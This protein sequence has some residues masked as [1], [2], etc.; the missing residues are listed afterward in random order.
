[1]STPRRSSAIAAA[2]RNVCG[3]T[4]LSAS[5]G[6]TRRAFVT[7]LDTSLCNASA[8]SRPPRELGKTGSLSSPACC[9][10]HPFRTATTSGRNGVHRCFLPLPKQ[11]TCAPVPNL[12]SCRLSEVI[13]LFRRPVWRASNR[14]ARSRRPI[15]VLV[16]GVANSAVP[17]SS[18]RNSGSEQESDTTGVS[19]GFPENYK[20]GPGRGHPLRLEQEIS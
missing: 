20:F 1:M 12:I 11:R 3:V 15:Q 14:S 19:C 5:D 7:Y 13:S 2:W 8:L 9:A 4:F 10:I 16:S 6:Q 18:V 17:S